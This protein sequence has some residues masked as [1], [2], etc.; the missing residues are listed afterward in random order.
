MPATTYQNPPIQEAIFDV[1]F[2]FTD[3]PS[4]ETLE[5]LWKSIEETFPKKETIQNF[6]TKVEFNPTAKLPVVN[7]TTSEPHGLRLTSQDGS[8]VVQIKRNGITISRLN[9]Y[10]GWDQFWTEA[11]NL[12]NKYSEV[13]TPEYAERIALRYIN[14]I[15][16]PEA[17][18]KLDDYFLTAPQVGSS[19]Q[20][21]VL[22]FF[23]QVM[24][25]DEGSNTLAIIN[26]TINP[27][28]REN[29]T[30]IIL[31]IDAFQDSLRIAPLSDAFAQSI[32]QIKKFRTS[33]F[34]GSIT[35]KTRSLFK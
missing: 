23:S 31:D 15:Q 30:T 6:Q 20:H 5:A 3:T 17:T 8:R 34:E 2:R 29:E 24:I 21:A 32:E 26:Q 1:R 14:S 18:F 25:K 35:E 28:K 11:N 10:D 22:K 33:I 9:G 4:M 12:L 13:C 27:P 19:I 16:I 7:S